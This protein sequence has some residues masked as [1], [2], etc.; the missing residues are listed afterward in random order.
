MIQQVLKVYPDEFWQC[1]DGGTHHQDDI[2]CVTY[3]RPNYLA[4]GSFD[5]QILVWNIDSEK[6]VAQFRTKTGSKLDTM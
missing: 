3:C 6:I 4:T 2:L 5:G 1:V